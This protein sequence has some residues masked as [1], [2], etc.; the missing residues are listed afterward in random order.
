MK[1]S[2]SCSDEAKGP[3]ISVFCWGACPRLKS[4]NLP[5]TLDHKSSSTIFEPIGDIECDYVNSSSVMSRSADLRRY[6]D[7]HCLQGPDC[8]HNYHF[9]IWTEVVENV[10]A[11]DCSFFPT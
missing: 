2:S 5:Y 10:Q 1:C 7:V 3:G 6:L 9:K 4:S 8:E 11:M